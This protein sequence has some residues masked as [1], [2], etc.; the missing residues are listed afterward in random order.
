[1]VVD[2]KSSH[3]RKIQS[4][5]RNQSEIVLAPSAKSRNQLHRNKLHQ[6][7]QVKFKYK[8]EGLDRDWNDVGTRRTAYYILLAARRIYIS[9]NPPP[10][11]M[12]SGNTV[13][14]G[15]QGQ[16]LPSLLQNLLVSG[17]LCVWVSSDDLD[18][19]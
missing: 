8:L 14:E 13:G 12:V 15:H 7:R 16:S 3:R 18:A 10:T 9:C 17:R 4:A 5:I 19:V 2:R 1:M 11:E 6:F